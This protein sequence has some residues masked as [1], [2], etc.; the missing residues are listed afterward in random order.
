MKCLGVGGDRKKNKKKT[1]GG[2][3][4]TWRPKGFQSP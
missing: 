3:A 1:K 2:G 4:T